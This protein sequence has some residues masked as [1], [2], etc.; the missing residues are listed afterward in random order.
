LRFICFSLAFHLQGWAHGLSD[1]AIWVHLYGGSVLDVKLA[2][3]ARVR[4]VQ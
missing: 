4:L 1:A 3:G 2:D